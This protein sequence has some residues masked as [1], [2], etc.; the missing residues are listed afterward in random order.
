MAILSTRLGRN[1]NQQRAAYLGVVAFNEIGDYES[2]E[3]YKQTLLSLEGDFDA[4]RNELSAMLT[5]EDAKQLLSNVSAV[6]SEFSAARDNLLSILEE[7]A[8]SREAVSGVVEEGVAEEGVA[9]E[10][11]AVEAAETAAAVATVAAAEAE[12]AETE[13]AEA[14]RLRNELDEAL[15]AVATPGANLLEAATLLTNFIDDL[16]DQQAASVAEDSRNVTILSAVILAAAVVAAMVLGLYLATSISK[17]VNIMRELLRQVGET[18]SFAFSDDMK[19][20]TRAAALFKD[21]VSQALAAIVKM[22]DQLILYG[23]ALEAVADKDLTVEVRTL[24]T[25]DTMGNALESMLGNLNNMFDEIHASADQVSSG[26]QQIANG[27]QTL[28]QGATEQAASVEQLSSA[29]TEVAD[30][31]KKAAESA[32]NAAEMSNNIRSKAEQ[33]SERMQAM[34]EAVQGINEASQ[35]IGKVIKV[36]DDIAFQTNILALNAAVE[37]A[38]AGAAGR[39]FAVVAE[40]VRNLAVKSAEAAQDTEALIENSISKAVLG[41]K[42]AGETNDALVE[43]VDGVISSAQ[44]SSEIADASDQQYAAIA[45]INTGVDQVAQVVQQNSATAEESAAASQQLSGQSAMLNSLIA[46]F[47]LKSAPS[48]RMPRAKEILDAPARRGA[49]EISLEA[50]GYGGYAAATDKY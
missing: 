35:N 10:G 38:R 3:T 20:K 15:K 49:P 22:M 29:I 39:G 13:T 28:A 32:R 21:E 12:T 44:I 40:E 5:T 31:I 7:V 30:S 36:I 50:V 18:G 4:F 14:A 48:Q 26:S 24:G 34:M 9:A 17:P 23:E 42:I 6:Y 27:A 41:V 2:A 45:E 33:G 8:A 19:N 1:V 43:I 11:G 37:A 16:T 25:Q 46:Q 47:N